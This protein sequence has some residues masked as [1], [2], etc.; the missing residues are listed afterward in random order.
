MATTLLVIAIIA[1]WSVSG[2]LAWGCGY[3]NG[4]LD[5]MQGRVEDPRLGLWAHFKHYSLGINQDPK[6]S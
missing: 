1:A 4:R 2:W 5:Q 6:K 3:F